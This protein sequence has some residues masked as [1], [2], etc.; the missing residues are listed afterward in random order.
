[1]KQEVSYLC[2]GSFIFGSSKLL[3]LNMIHDLSM[4]LEIISFVISA[5]VLMELFVVNK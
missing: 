3:V 1:M 4:Q 5:E 2:F